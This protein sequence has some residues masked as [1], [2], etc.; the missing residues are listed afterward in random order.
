MRTLFDKPIRFTTLDYYPEKMSVDE[1]VQ[2]MQ[3]NLVGFAANMKTLAK[4]GTES[5]WYADPHYVEQWTETFLAWS[6]IEEKQ[7]NE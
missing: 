4:P 6:E 5:G 3:A 7:D 2:T 1:F